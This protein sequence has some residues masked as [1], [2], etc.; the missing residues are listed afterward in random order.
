MASLFLVQIAIALVVAITQVPFILKTI[1]N[2][3]Q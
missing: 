1:E 3:K 2:K